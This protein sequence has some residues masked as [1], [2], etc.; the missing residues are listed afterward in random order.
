[1][2]EANYQ[3]DP[4]RVKQDI[5]K[6]PS[7]S[8]YVQ[9]AA[10]AAPQTYNS[11]SGNLLGSSSDLLIPIS[12]PPCT[13]TQK[14]EQELRIRDFGLSDFLSLPVAF[15]NIYLGE[16]F[17]SYLCI[18][19]ESGA[20]VQDAGI[21]AEL[22][23]ASQRLTLA[24][25]VTSILPSSSS[26]SPSPP[27]VTSS[28][29]LP[30]QSAE[31]LIHHEIKELGIHILVCSVHYSVGAERKYFRKFYKFQ[32]LNPLAV[33]TKV[34]TLQDGRIFLEAQ[35][36]NVSGTPMFL[37]RLGFEPS[38]LFSF[39]DLTVV[40]ERKAAASSA[41]LKEATDSTVAASKTATSSSL[42][43]S[44]PTP[45][46]RSVFGMSKHLANQD[47]RQYLYLLEPKSPTD[48]ISRSTPTLGKLDIAWRTQLGQHGRL[49]T[50]QLS[51]KVQQPEPFEISVVSVET[52]ETGG[53][54]LEYLSSSSTAA[55]GTA[56]NATV[57]FAER[58]FSLT[59]QIRNNLPGESLRIIV[60]GV[61]SKMSSVLLWGASETDAGEVRALESVPVVLRFFPL[62]SGLH[63]VTGLRLMETLSGTSRDID[64]L[65]EVFVISSSA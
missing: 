33:K 29:L 22:Q 43:T 2:L 5:I 10:A 40:K 44:T 9:A 32:V 45:T 57:V 3:A 1:M 11:G 41:M 36:Q 28:S 20:T 49:Q 4:I 34:N 16:T 12:S 6:S 15:G 42:S 54:S 19:N 62:V 24:D 8:Q 47:T 7:P 53:K 25:T 30:S 18:N 63:K 52:E 37:E 27:V 61:K 23:T 50:S 51:R 39:T 48:P 46:P 38:G 56:A 64:V 60:S 35:V 55:T 59:C 58:P 21:K 17:S 26:S 13:N 65:T 31:F 14:P